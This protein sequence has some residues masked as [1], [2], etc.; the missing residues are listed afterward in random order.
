MAQMVLNGQILRAL[1]SL[2]NSALFIDLSGWS[3]ETKD[4]SIYCFRYCFS[5][6]QC[7]TSRLSQT[8]QTCIYHS[9]HAKCLFYDF[10]IKIRAFT[11]QS[12]RPLVANRHNQ[13]VRY[14][15]GSVSYVQLT[16]WYLPKI[17]INSNQF[18][19]KRNNR[20][21]ELSCYV[22]VSSCLMAFSSEVHCKN[23]VFVVTA[24]AWR[25]H[26]NKERDG[27][28]GFCWTFSL[29]FIV[30][31]SSVIDPVLCLLCCSCFWH[32]YWRHTWP[33]LPHCRNVKS[34]VI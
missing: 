2:G 15:S 14:N 24:F 11:G 8:F 9:N 18:L 25:D 31:F 22:V 33:H 5:I 17:W 28:R 7:V 19:T 29:I 34:P 1:S 13:K 26:M 30:F 16:D 20:E 6:S 21:K 32:R 27:V 3:L 23:C 12:A 4:V 10:A